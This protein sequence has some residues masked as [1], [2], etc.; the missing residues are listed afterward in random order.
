MTHACH[1]C[2]SPRT[3][4]VF[5]IRGW[6]YS[7]CRDCHSLFVL[8]P[9][10]VE[11]TADLYGDEQYFIQSSFAQPDGRDLPGY[12][13]DYL[14]DRAN[15]ERKFAEV[16]AHAERHRAPGHLLDVG[17]GPG[18]LIS[19]AR[20]RGWD[21]IGLDLNPW[22]AK[23]AR[24]EL[25]VQVGTE[26]FI[27]A[28]FAPATFDAVTMMDLIEHVG[29]P[30]ELV[31]EAARVIKPGGL[32]VILTPDAGSPVSRALGR[33]WPE[34]RRAPEHL[35]LFSVSGL[36]HLV[37]REG[38]SPREWHYIGKRT[39]LETLLAD[40]SLAAPRL[41]RALRPM[42]EGT[43][44]GAVTGEVDPRTKFCLYAVRTT[45]SDPQQRR[46]APV[47]IPKRTPDVRTTEEAILD[48]LRTLARMRVLCD[49]MFEQVAAEVG[50]VAVEVGA[51]IGTFSRRL[52][53]SGAE[54]LLL[55]EP[56]PSCADALAERFEGDPR[57]TLSRDLLPDSPALADWRGSADIVL[58]QNVLEHIEDD[59]AAVL[60]MA[61]ALRPGGTLALLVPANPRLFGSLDDAYGHHR[62]YT[63]AR[64]HALAEAAGLEILDLRYFNLLGVPGWW[65][66]NRTGAVGIGPVALRTYEALLW[67]WR[68][69]ERRWRPPTGLSLIV[70]ARAP[71]PDAVRT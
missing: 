40:V 44:L 26:T 36:A 54:R 10:S 11:E 71:D 35:S 5:T 18:F 1:G 34:V 53:E 30:S 24:E 13:G 48:E 58:C 16:L 6:R 33:R 27:D 15:I 59:R 9:P 45:E 43:R 69:V 14:A 50:P 42:V 32:L 7:R 57:I 39:S 22:A 55:I 61:R 56:E 17:A 49:W 19:A 38:F 4:A 23:Y 31:R 65:V 21:A 47:R 29:D 60:S 12:G 52:L 68:G 25:G 63:P 67:M 37:K 62:R 2:G 3:R 46:D 20:D 51:G 66:K 70:H 64:L 8:D 28:A 41:S